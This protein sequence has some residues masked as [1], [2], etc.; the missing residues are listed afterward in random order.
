MFS[1]VGASPCVGMVGGTLG[2]GVSRYNG[3]HGMILD[4]L[5]SVKIITGTG[6]LLTAS[7]TENS[8]LFWGI[9]GAGMNYGII[10]SATYQVYDLT[11]QNVMVADIDLPLNKSGELID[12]L[13]G[14]G[15]QLPEKLSIVLRSSYSAANGGVSSPFPL[16]SYPLSLCSLTDGG[17]SAN[18]NCSMSIAEPSNQHC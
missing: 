1:E 16:P 8:D 15:D 3:L 9:R 12:Y 18:Q 6:E 2:G 4:A 10:L 13:K 14:Y 5:K 11:S 17:I 7:E